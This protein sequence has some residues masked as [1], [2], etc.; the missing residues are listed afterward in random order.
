MSIFTP[1]ESDQFQIG[2]RK[3]RTSNVERNR[4][5]ICDL[6]HANRLQG[7]S[8]LAYGWNHDCVVLRQRPDRLFHYA[9][10][11]GTNALPGVHPK[12]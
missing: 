8:L 4:R 6:H 11:F 7:D 2:T 1:V 12:G 10:F 5:R 9:V 3:A